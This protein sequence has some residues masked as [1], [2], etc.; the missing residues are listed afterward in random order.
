[1]EFS[2]VENQAVT[3]FRNILSDLHT[4]FEMSGE[5]CTFDEFLYHNLPM[6]GLAAYDEIGAFFGDADTA[7]TDL[8]LGE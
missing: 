5:D 3:V 1:M 6:L 7:V 8:G 4:A 2:T